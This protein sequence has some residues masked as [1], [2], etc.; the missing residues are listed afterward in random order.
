MAGGKEARNY[1]EC[2]EAVIYVSMA[3]GRAILLGV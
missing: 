3:D 2:G 1:G